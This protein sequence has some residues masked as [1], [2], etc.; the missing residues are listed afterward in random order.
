M[1]KKQPAFVNHNSENNNKETSLDYY[2]S[3]TDDRDI[4]GSFAFLP[5]EECYLNLPDDIVEDNPLDTENI[6]E[7]Q[8][9]DNE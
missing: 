4:L 8:D 1:G 7:Q 9:A 5:D 6:K 2:F 3:W